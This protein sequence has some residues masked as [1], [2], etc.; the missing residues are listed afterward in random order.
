MASENVNVRVTGELRHYFGIT[1]HLTNKIYLDFNYLHPFVP[2]RTNSRISSMVI[3]SSPN[4]FTV[5][6]SA[7]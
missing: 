3:P 4:L 7:Q 5:R 2:V 6:P 1:N